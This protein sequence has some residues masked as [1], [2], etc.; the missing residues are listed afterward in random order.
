MDSNEIMTLEE[1]AALMRVHT[2]TIS[3]WAKGGKLS[4][5]KVGGQWRF[6][7]DLIE[8]KTRPAEKTTT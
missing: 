6:R 4:G 7:R 2:A 1:V 3:R 5:F 8:A